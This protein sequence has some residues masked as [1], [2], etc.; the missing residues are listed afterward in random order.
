MLLTMQTVLRRL[1]YER[2]QIS[3]REVDIIFEAPTTERIERLWQPTISLFL[4]AIHENVELRQSSYQ[5][6][7]ANG[8]A[9]RRPLPRR[10]DLRY[11]VTAI[12]SEIEDEQQLLWRV[13][14]TLVRHPQ[15]PEAYLPLEVQAL[16]I[17]LVAHVGR[18]DEQQVLLSLWNSLGSP[19][20][21]ALAYTVTVPIELAP[22]AEAPLV[23]QRT[24]RYRRLSPGEEQASES[25]IQLGG[26]V[27]NQQGQALAG[28][29]V[30][31]EGYAEESITDSTGRFV[32]GHLPPQRAILRLTPPTG[33]AR[34]LVIDYGDDA[35]PAADQP[36]PR[37]VLSYEIVLEALPVLET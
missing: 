36:G 25:G 10:F 22:V 15:I 1:L 33:P 26:L 9:E 4:Y 30:A 29:H 18:E 20:R 35:A 28:V 12:S 11:M 32:L 3:E 17:P 27:R 31:L 19:P 23:L 2:G 8:R 16:G 24:A 5:T 34:R 37:S 13:L 21:P 14:T 7:A 6:V